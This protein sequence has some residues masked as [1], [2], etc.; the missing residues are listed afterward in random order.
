MWSFRKMDNESFRINIYYFPRNAFLIKNVNLFQN[1]N[2]NIYA[3]RDYSK[4]Q[5]LENL[6]INIPSISYIQPATFLKS[7][8]IK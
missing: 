8:M 2:I 3:K 4:H 1:K 6:L 5:G 7:V